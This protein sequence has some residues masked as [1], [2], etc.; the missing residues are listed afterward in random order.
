MY[1]I[2]ITISCHRKR[3]SFI[4]LSSHISPANLHMYTYTGRANKNHRDAK[5]TFC[6]C[7]TAVQK[8]RIPVTSSNSCTEYDPISVIFGLENRQR[9]FSLQ[10]SNW[11]VFMKL[12]TSFFT[13]QWT[14]AAD[15]AKMGVCE[16]HRISNKKI[17][18]SLKVMERRDWWKNFWRNDERRL[19][20]TIFF[21][22]FERTMYKCS[23]VRQQKTQNF[24]YS[25]KQQRRQRP[26]F[27]PGR[28][29]PDASN[30]VT[31]FQKNRYQSFVSCPY[32]SRRLTSSSVW[33]NDTCRSCRK[34]KQILST[35]YEIN[36]SWYPVSWKLACYTCEHRRHIAYFVYQELWILISISWSHLKI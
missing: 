17:C 33:K 8:N 32:N 3:Y 2:Y 36:L 21:K 14:S 22:T 34:P 31:Y 30:I 25:S 5:F 18:T 24:L 28:R 9:V 26:W 15:D 27:V 1:I 4:L 20:W 23:E 19:L 7:Y 10:L 35:V 6:R 16:E 12:G 29:S 13:W 11:R